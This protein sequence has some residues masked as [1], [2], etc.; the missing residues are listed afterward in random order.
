VDGFSEPDAAELEALD[1]RFGDWLRDGSVGVDAATLEY[2]AGRELPE[3]RDVLET[4]GRSATGLAALLGRWPDWG[5]VDVP[6]EL[7]GEYDRW[8]DLQKR[9]TADNVTVL[10]APVSGREHGAPP[11]SAA[12]CL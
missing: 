6:A 8:I 5:V 9:S 11:V 4:P 10:L 12:A 2:V 3:L 1:R 7:E